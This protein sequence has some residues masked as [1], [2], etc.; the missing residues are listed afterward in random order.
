MEKLLE[1][2]GVRE[3]PWG[4]TSR[5]LLLARLSGLWKGS[6]TNEVPFLASLNLGPN[7]ETWDGDEFSHSCCG[8]R[9][10]NTSC[11]L[12]VV[13]LAEREAAESEE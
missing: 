1:L 6:K 8:G 10:P 12:Y 7:P 13:S 4:Q 3:T 11:D 9:L 5:E 2:G